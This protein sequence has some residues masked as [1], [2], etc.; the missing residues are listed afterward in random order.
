MVKASVGKGF[1]YLFVGLFATSFLIINLI[2]IFFAVTLFVNIAFAEASEISEVNKTCLSCHQ[3]QE[4]YLV[5][6]SVHEKLDCSTCHTSYSQFPHPQ[7]TVVAQEVQ[8]MCQACHGP[9]AQEYSESVHK[10]VN[11]ESSQSVSCTSCHGSHDILKGE[12]PEAK[13]NRLNINESCISC[14]DGGVV[15]SYNWSFHGTA[16]NFG[17]TE[18]AN[19]VD[20]HGSHN[21]LPEDNPDSMVN[22]ANR[23]ETC[24]E[25]HNTARENFALGSEH[26]TPYDKVNAL[27]LY[28]TMQ[29]FVILILFD[30][31][32]DSTIA[33][34]DLFKK[35]RGHKSKKDQ[36]PSRNIDV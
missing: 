29:I 26:R 11:D 33:I 8:T 9:V 2:G 31:T 35:V 10:Y 19:C 17:Y 25:C 34:F 22:V 28:I 13:H 1:V 30:A 5:E 7:E 12:N 27:P 18:A 16:F 4:K 21:I 24:A 3:E 36:T 23:P 32:K 15:D 14:H 6:G 20:C